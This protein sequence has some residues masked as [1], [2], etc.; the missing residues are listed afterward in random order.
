MCPPPYSAAVSPQTGPVCSSSCPPGSFPT[1]EN[2]NVTCRPGYATPICPEG[3]SF[4]VMTPAGPVCQQGYLPVAAAN[5]SFACN[6]GDLRVERPPYQLNGALAYETCAPAPNCPAGYIEAV[7][8][9]NALGSS[10]VCMLPCQDFV[11]NQSMA[12]SCG[13]G[14]RLAAQQPG[15]PA[16]QIC[17]PS[18]RAG[19]Q[20]VASSPLYA[21][22]AEEGQCIPTGGG[23]PVALVDVSPSCPGAT[24]WNG[25]VCL[26]IGGG[27]GVPILVYG[28]CPVDTH[29]NGSHCVPDFI[30]PPICG[31]GTHWNGLFCVPNA[32]KP[33]PIFT[34][35]DGSKCVPII[36]QVCPV[37]QYWD[38]TKCVPKLVGCIPPKKIINGKCVQPFVPPPLCAPPK[39]IVNGQ[40]VLPPPPLCAPPKKIVNGQC[41]LPPPPLCAPPKKIVN[42]KCV[43]PPPP[44]FCKPP[45]K[46]I[47]GQ[48]V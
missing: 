21:F 30:P 45:K 44:L 18:C 28:G 4:M 42:G 31:P 38:G 12:C 11:M 23:P 5:N 7:D 34:K 15:A 1:L 46:L 29:W 47:N 3:N 41:V 20:W 6:P 32:P 36:Q 43:L 16:K 2:G 39:K 25:Q 35:S 37:N 13:S 26:P 27:G 19:S 10:R 9:D 24:Y 48:C 33:C 17:Q 22:K 14:G 8:P 40:C